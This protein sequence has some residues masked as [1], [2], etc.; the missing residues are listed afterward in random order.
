VAR[1]II[2]NLKD[3]VLSIVQYFRSVVVGT[4]LAQIRTKQLVEDKWVDIESACHVVKQ[5][6]HNAMLAE[7]ITKQSCVAML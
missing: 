2:I 1:L 5:I 4:W 7:V 3:S 6:T